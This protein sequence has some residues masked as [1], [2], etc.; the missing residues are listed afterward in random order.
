MR[1]LIIRSNYFRATRNNALAIG[2]EMSGGVK[3]VF[4]E[5]NTFGKVPKYVIYLKANTDRGGSIENVWMRNNFGT[6]TSARGA[7]RIESGFNNVTNHPYP[8]VYRD[9]HFENSAFGKSSGAGISIEGLEQK[10]IT[11]VFFSDITIESAT[12][13]ALIKFAD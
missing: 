3:N 2:S 10:H 4:A 5:D 8:P 6:N 1:E 12:N 7:F 9:L 11:N 13:P